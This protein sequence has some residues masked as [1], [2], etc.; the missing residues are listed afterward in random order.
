[1]DSNITNFKQITDLVNETKALLTQLDSA[2]TQK[3]K[4]IND[5]IE[6]N[7]NKLLYKLTQL[8]SLLMESEN[9]EV[10]QVKIRECE[11]FLASLAIKYDG[12]IENELEEGILIVKELKQGSNELSTRLQEQITNIQSINDKIKDIKDKSI[13]ALDN[14]SNKMV[15]TSKWKLY[16]LIGLEAIVAVYLIIS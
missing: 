14:F 5:K 1:M 8:Q 9:R 7:R 15:E 2:S 16:L 10:I 11:E 4:E 3:K 6:S 13:R 12:F